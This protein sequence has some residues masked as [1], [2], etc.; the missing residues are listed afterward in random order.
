LRRST[1]A[2]LVVAAAALLGSTLPASAGSGLANPSP[3]RADSGVRAG[4]A[5]AAPAKAVKAVVVKSWSNCSSGSVVWD[6]LNA[7]WSSYGSIPITIDYSNPSL[8]A[9]SFTLAALEASKADVVILDDPSGHVV[10]FTADELAALQTYAE[11]G[12]DLIGTYL[13]FAYPAQGIDNTGLAPLFGL[14][15]DAGWAG[16]D[17]NIVATY[18]LNKKVKGVKPLFR[19]LP[20]SYVST[21]YNSS[22]IPGDGAWSKNDLAGA[23]LVGI[24]A[25]KSAAITLYRQGSYNAVFIANMPEYNG[26][27]QD[28]QFIYN[29]IIYPKKG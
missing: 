29:A 1:S 7:N 14:P 12:H 20:N 28:Q 5:A 17:N 18:K 25:D 11:E 24:N 8:C 16:G 19:G 9:D 21:G 3:A 10:E 26:G 13:T 23:K 4:S 27:V 2:V 6:Q 22:Q 15:K